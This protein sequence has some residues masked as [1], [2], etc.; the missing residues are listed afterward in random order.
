MRHSIFAREIP[1]AILWAFLDTV[2]KYHDT[3]FFI[4]KP[5]FQKMIYDGKH[6]PF[7]E[8][9]K[10]YYKPKHTYLE[11]TSHYNGFVTI[12]RQICNFHNHPY[13]TVKKYNHCDYTICYVIERPTTKYN[14][15]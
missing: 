1:L 12:L 11:N 15:I 5:V 7:L 8:S 13:T 10:P 2:C 9:L 4:D 3:Y 6:L 14:I